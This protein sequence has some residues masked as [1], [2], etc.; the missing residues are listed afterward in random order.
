MIIKGIC[1]WI[2]ILIISGLFMNHIFSRKETHEQRIIELDEDIARIKAAHEREA[3]Q[4]SELLK[5]RQ[6]LSK[7]IEHEIERGESA[8][9]LLGVNVET[10]SPPAGKTP[11]TSVEKVVTKQI[12]WDQIPAEQGLEVGDWITVEGYQDAFIGARIRV[13]NG[14]SYGLEWTV[15]GLIDLT[16]KPTAFSA[17]SDGINHIIGAIENPRENEIVVRIN[18]AL[19]REETVLIRVTGQIYQITRPNEMDRYLNQWGVIL[20]ES[21]YVEFM[22]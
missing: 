5:E 13:Q 22:E 16:S 10:E 4:K 9:L 19:L 17:P 1:F 18:E 11:P 2:V 14:I 8:K 3:K 20:K 7:K 15:S 12:F 6:E 21:V